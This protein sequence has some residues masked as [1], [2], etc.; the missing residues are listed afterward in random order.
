MR[1]VIVR[2]ISQGFFLI[3]LV[4]SCLVTTVG[5]RWYEL[6][7]WPV[8]WLLELDPLVG[9]ATLLTTGTVYRG[10]IWGVVTLGLTA[11]IGRF[12]CGWICPLGTLQHLF[13][14]WGD[15]YRKPPPP[16]GRA[17][18]ASCPAGEVL[19]ARRSADHGRR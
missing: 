14:A 7:G 11:L 12:F 13:G 15:R 2:R 8:G 3:L 18:S 10:L 6:R 16:G 19:A 1:L 4:W 5:E 9:L 17:A